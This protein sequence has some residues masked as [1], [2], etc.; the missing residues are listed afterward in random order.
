MRTSKKTPKLLVTGLCEGNP[1]FT[2]GFPSQRGSNAED[3]SIWWR[4]HATSRYLLTRS[5]HRLV[6]VRKQ[7]QLLLTGDTWVTQLKLSK[8]PHPVGTNSCWSHYT[9]R[10]S[11]LDSR[12][13]WWHGMNKTLYCVRSFFFTKEPF[14]N[15]AQVLY[16]QALVPY[17]Y[18]PIGVL[19]WSLL[20]VAYRRNINTQWHIKAKPHGCCIFSMILHEAPSMETT[21]PKGE[22]FPCWVAEWSIMEN[23]QQQMWFCFYPSPISINISIYV[24][25]APRLTPEIWCWAMPLASFQIDINKYFAIVS[26]RCQVI[27]N[28]DVM[29]PWITWQNN[30]LMI[31]RFAILSR[32]YLLQTALCNQ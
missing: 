4:H 23:M 10:Q 20:W 11:W 22:W 16:L 5:P 3:S 26:P 28:C 18:A 14:E 7:V 6:S 15:D 1:P 27:S 8:R 31:S 2:G 12:P 9:D 21:T 25:N 30:R 13:S 24:Y 19:N 29:S 32:E 17:I